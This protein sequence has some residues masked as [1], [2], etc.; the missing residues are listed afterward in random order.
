V[1][2]FYEVVRD[3]ALSSGILMIIVAFAGLL[4]WTGSTLGVMEKVAAAM[5]TVSTDPFWVLMMINGILLVAGCLMDGVSIWYIFTPIMIPIIKYFNWDFTWFGVVMALNLS[6]GTVTPPV[7]LN[8]F[9][10][11]NLANISMETISKAVLPFFLALLVALLITSYVPLLSLWF[12]T[13]IGLH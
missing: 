13:I 7:A 10:A 9:V 8:L 11:S 2:V 6:I 5:L 4:G 12:P 1:K 3:S